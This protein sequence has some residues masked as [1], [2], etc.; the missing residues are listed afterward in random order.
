MIST[1]AAIFAV[2][3]ANAGHTRAPSST[4][5]DRVR[6]DE[7]A[8]APR[9]HLRTWPSTFF[10]ICSNASIYATYQGRRRACQTHVVGC[11]HLV[12]WV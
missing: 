8:V 7:R 1:F 12:E 4:S 11:V 6:Y 9:R 3:R 5:T 10:F 2:D